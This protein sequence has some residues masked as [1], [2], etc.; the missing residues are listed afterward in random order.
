MGDRFLK[1]ELQMQLMAEWERRVVVLERGE[2]S[3]SGREGERER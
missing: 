3:C 1:H 2:K